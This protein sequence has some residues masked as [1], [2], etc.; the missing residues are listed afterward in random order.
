[1]RKRVAG[2]RTYKGKNPHTDHVH[3]EFTR[4]GSQ[5][6]SLDAILIDVGIIRT[7]Y[8]ELQAALSGFA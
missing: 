4:A 2:W 7:G 8:D 5:L 3:V 6:Q 1:M